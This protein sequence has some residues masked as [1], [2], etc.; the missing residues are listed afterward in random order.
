MRPP[1]GSRGGPWQ[2]LHVSMGAAA[3]TPSGDVP[4]QRPPVVFCETALL[5]VV[6]GVRVVSAE[7]VRGLRG[8]AENVLQAVRQQNFSVLG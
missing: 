6:C 3:Q 5:C 4:P 2:Q 7:W 1:E 8:D